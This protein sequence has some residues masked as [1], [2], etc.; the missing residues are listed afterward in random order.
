MNWAT[1]V[2]F[3]SEWDAKACQTYYANF[4]VYPFG[5]ITKI[6]A[7]RIPAHQLLLAGFPCQAFS[8]M[9]KMKGF[10]NTRGTMFY[11]IE[12]ILEYHRPPYILLESVKQL[13]GHDGGR[14]FKIILDH[15]NSLGY[16]IKWKVLNALDFGLPQKRERVIIVG[17][18]DKA[19]YDSFNFDFTQ[20]DGGNCKTQRVV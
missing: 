15:L 14:T 7:E 17:F 13:V 9:G 12:R 4:G 6:P 2:C 3:T 19:D 20:K 8:I 10:A 16:F 11:E 1:I 5:D 18:T